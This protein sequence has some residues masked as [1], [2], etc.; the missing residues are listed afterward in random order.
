MDPR[1]DEKIIGHFSMTILFSPAACSQDARGRLFADL[2][3]LSM[4]LQKGNSSRPWWIVDVCIVDVC[5]A[6]RLF[7]Q[8]VFHI[9]STQNDCLCG[10]LLG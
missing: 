5:S 8:M 10:H 7:T 3:L 4:A 1:Q 9:I 2:G 6:R